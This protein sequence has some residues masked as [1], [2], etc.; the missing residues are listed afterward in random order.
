MWECGLDPK[1]N[2]KNGSILDGTTRWKS[3]GLWDFGMGFWYGISGGFQTDT[4]GNQWIVGCL[5]TF[6]ESGSSARSLEK[7]EFENEESGV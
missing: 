6:G 1:K 3:M 4:V 5:A 7:V 2:Q